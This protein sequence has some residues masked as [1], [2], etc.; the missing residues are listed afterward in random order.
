MT[1]DVVDGSAMRDLTARLL[2]PSWPRSDGAGGCSVEFDRADAVEQVLDQLAVAGDHIGH[3]A[4]EQHLEADDHQHRRQDQRLQ[5][6]VARAGEVVVEKP[7]RDGEAGQGRAPE[8][9]YVNT[10]S[11]S[12]IA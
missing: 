6:P 11:G 1:T 8:P 12:Y 4:D 2:R 3:Q 7:R 9:M 5:V 10:L